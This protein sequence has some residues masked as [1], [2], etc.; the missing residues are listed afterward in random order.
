MNRTVKTE[1]VLGAYRV[2]STAKLNKLS[3]EDKVIA[4]KIARILKPVADRFDDDSKDAAEKMK[5]SEDFDERLQKAQ[6]Y[7]RALKDKDG[8]MTNV[9]ISASEYAKTVEEVVGY[10]KLVSKAIK[11]FAEKEVEL[12]FA[13]IS[14]N[15]FG[16]LMASNDGWTVEQV[17][18]LGDIICE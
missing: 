15:A 11:D 3:D 2:L 4:W 14:E 1:K 5:P 16:L 12:D 7:E 13:P 9:E 6:A 17:M 8:D 10:N 18:M